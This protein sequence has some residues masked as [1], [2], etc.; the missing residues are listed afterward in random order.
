[1][2]YNNSISSKQ[3]QDLLLQLLLLSI[4]IFTILNCIA[5]KYNKNLLN[6]IIY[7][8]IYLVI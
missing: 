1:M 3:I 7:L 2:N 5:K 4:K 8:Q 6:E